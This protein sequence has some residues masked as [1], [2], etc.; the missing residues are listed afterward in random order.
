MPDIPI[1]HGLNNLE[2]GV[3]LEYAD[4]GLVFDGTAPDPL[5]RSWQDQLEDI[6]ELKELNK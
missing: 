4:K 6:E 5:E 3:F 2:I 1:D